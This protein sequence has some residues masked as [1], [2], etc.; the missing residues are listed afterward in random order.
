MQSV[1]VRRLFR[2][3]RPVFF[4]LVAVPLLLSYSFGG[5]AT[6]TVSGTQ[7]GTSTTYLGA[8]EGSS[9]FN[10]ADLTD[11]GINTYRMYGGMSRWEWQDDSSVYGS[12]SIDQIKAN[13]GVINWAWWDNVMTNPPGGSDYC[14]NGVACTGVPPVNART[15]FQSLNNNKIKPIVVLRN[16]DNNGNP[17]WSPNP[18]KTQADWN[19]WWEHVFATVYWLN[20]RNT[21]IVDDFEV[22]NEPDKSSQGWG[23]TETDYEEFVRQTSD[24]IKY[25]YSTY[26]PGRTPHIY[27]PVTASCCSWADSVMRD[28]GPTYFDSLDFHDY[29]SNS[30]GEVETLRSY[31]NT[32]GFG[33][34]PVW[35]SEH[36]SWHQNSYDSVTNGN[37]MILANWI[38]GSSPGQ[39]HVDGFALFSLYDWGSGYTSGAIH[40]NYPTENKTPGYYAMRMAAR[41]LVGGRP[42]YQVTSSN[43]NLVT[44]ATKDAAG[45][46]YLIVCNTGS[47]AVTV[48]ADLSALITTGTG[49]QWEYSSSYLDT[50]VANPVLSNGK[51]TFTVQANGSE[52]L[53]F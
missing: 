36:G 21:Y 23:G 22:H 20:V 49:T 14:W 53:K 29:Q 41:A 13:P 6:V 26:L 27:A 34:A 5:N 40:G 3:I 43:S 16:R 52:L 31:M 1:E 11:L 24:A 17:T 2:A 25:V 42:T 46:V 50:V 10:I 7:W 48:T 28:V 38:R 12:P 32:D 8:N 44:V 51:V 45:A 37:S 35:I 4:T 30:L 9:N 18:P 15:I 33:G 39:D 19:E 47:P